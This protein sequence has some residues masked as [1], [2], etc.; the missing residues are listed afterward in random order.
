M[1][2]FRLLTFI[3]CSFVLSNNCIS[4]TQDTWNLKQQKLNKAGMYSLLSWS[5][6]NIGTGI[7][8]NYALTGERKYFHQMNAMWN[9]VNLG[10]ATSGLIQERKRDLHAP[11]SVWMNSNKR[12]QRIFAINTALD[13]VYMGTGAVLTQQDSER[14]KGYGKSLVVQGAF[15]AV[16]DGIMWYR[17]KHQCK[18]KTKGITAQIGLTGYKLTYT[19]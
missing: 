2:S 14:M 9:V 17:H 5:G 12:F 8:G 10:L 1:K 7:V 15:L 19:F 18:Q 4:Q 13:F 16:F 6:V 3:L 11:D